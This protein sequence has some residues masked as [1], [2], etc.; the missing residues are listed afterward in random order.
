MF[1]LKTKENQILF[2]TVVVTKHKPKVSPLTPDQPQV[3]R[4]PL[5]L[6]I[7]SNFLGFYG[8]SHGT[9]FVAQNLVYSKI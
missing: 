5:S 2:L 6:Q 8:L 7:T 9:T 3:K 1:L 4:P